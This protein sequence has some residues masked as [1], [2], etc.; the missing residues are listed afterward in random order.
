MPP[1]QSIERLLTQVVK[2]IPRKSKQYR[3]DIGS[4]PGKVPVVV[5]MQEH[6]HKKGVAGWLPDCLTA[7]LPGCLAAWLP[8]C[9]AAWWAG[10][11]CGARGW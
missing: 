9:L 6:A 2:A 11:F 10:L 7:W 3:E 5:P 1:N 8:G 4:K